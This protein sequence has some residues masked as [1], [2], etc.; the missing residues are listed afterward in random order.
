[1][2]PD[3]IPQQTR[4]Q[5]ETAALVTPSYAGDFERCRLLCETVDRFVTGATKH[6]LLVAGHDVARFRALESA[7]RIVIDERDLLPPWLHG[8]R[9]PL[10]LFRRHVW[11]STRTAPLRGWHVQQLRRIAIAEKVPEAALVYCDSDVAFLKPLDVSVFWRNGAVRLY[12]RD[13]ALPVG[14][15]VGNHAE[16]LVNA[17]HVLSLPPQPAHLHDYISTVIAWRRETVISMMR[18]IEEHH[19]RHWVEVIASRRRFSECILY[20]RY[21]DEVLE[22]RGHFHDATQFCRVY[23]F[24]PP[25]DADGLRRLVEEMEPAQVAIGVQSFMGTDLDAVRRLVG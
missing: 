8:V 23:W 5:T 20:G 4:Y 3:P 18:H 7:N 16:W 1:M 25:L 24:G 6:Y 14:G 21:V 9:D 12:R 22:G 10:S 13:G 19:H 11:L 17:G 2:A 15:P